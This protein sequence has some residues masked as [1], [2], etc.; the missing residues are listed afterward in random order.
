MKFDIF[1][2][3]SSSLYRESRANVVADLKHVD[4]TMLPK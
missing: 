2:T 3:I 1:A 4:K